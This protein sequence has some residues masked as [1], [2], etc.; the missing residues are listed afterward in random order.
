[1]VYI[2]IKYDNKI[3]TTEYSYDDALNYINFLEENNI[4]YEISKENN[5]NYS[6]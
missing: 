3:Y 1:M 4:W 2:S 6:I 5:M